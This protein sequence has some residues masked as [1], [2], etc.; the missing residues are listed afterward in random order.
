MPRRWVAVTSVMS[1]IS[2]A[3]IAA[4]VVAEGAPARV[5]FAFGSWWSGYLTLGAMSYGFYIKDGRAVPRTLRASLSMNEEADGGP[6]DEEIAA[7]CDCQRPHGD[8][9]RGISMECPIHG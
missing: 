6:T 2:V 3:M 8:G 4:S 1:V 5:V 7:G 9:V